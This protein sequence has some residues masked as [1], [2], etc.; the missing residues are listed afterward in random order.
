M[1]R[2]AALRLLKN[3]LQFLLSRALLLSCVS[4][5]K[6]EFTYYLQCISQ[7]VYLAHYVKNV[8]CSKNLQASISDFMT[9]DNACSTSSVSACQ[10]RILHWFPLCHVTQLQTR[11]CELRGNCEMDLNKT[12]HQKVLRTSCCISIHR[13]KIH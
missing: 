4:T 7:M 9:A 2:A 6:F 1:I 5:V 13:L 3:K 12:I 8:K 10:L 11:Q